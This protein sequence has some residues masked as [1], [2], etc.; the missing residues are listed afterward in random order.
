MMGGFLMR[1][2]IK[3]ILGMVSV[4]IMLGGMNNANFLVDNERDQSNWKA[5]E[6]F[7]PRGASEGMKFEW[8]QN[9]TVDAGLKVM[10][11]E[12]DERSDIVFITV[13]GSTEV[14]IG[15][16][17]ACMNRS[18]G[19]I[20]WEYYF[21][22]NGVFESIIA[23]LE[24]DAHGNLYAAGYIEINDEMYSLVKF[25]GDSG[26]ILWKKSAS[27]YN[28]YAVVSNDVGDVYL[29]GPTN[30]NAYAI[31]KFNG[32]NGNLL[33]TIPVANSELNI[34]KEHLALDSDQNLILACANELNDHSICKYDSATGAQLWNTTWVTSI[35]FWSDTFLAIDSQDNPF[36]GGTNTTGDNEAF[37]RKFDNENGNSL[38]NIT[39]GSSLLNIGV[40][41]FIID[42]FD[43]MYLTGVDSAPNSYLIKFN[44]TGEELWNRTLFPGIHSDDNLVVGCDSN[45]TLFLGRTDNANDI[46]YLECYLLC[47]MVPDPITTITSISDIGNVSLTWNIPNENGL[48]ITQYNI[49]RGSVSGG[50][51]ELIGTSGTNSFLD[52]NFEADENNIP[53][54][55]SITAIN[56]IGESDN[57]TDHHARAGPYVY[58]VTPVENESIVFGIG[59]AKL[60][61][62]YKLNNV[63]LV[64]LEIEGTYRLYD[65]TDTIGNVTIEL[66]YTVDI[67]GPVTA[68]L[69]GYQGNEEI[70]SEARNFTFGKITQDVLEVLESNTTIVGEVLYSIL[71]DPMG[72]NSY[73]SY[74]ESTT[75]EWGFSSSTQKDFGVSLEVGTFVSLSAGFV[76]FSEVG[77]SVTCAFT[78]SDKE[79]FDTIFTATKMSGMTSS[80]ET[81]D[82]DRIGP[83]RG[84]MYWGQG[85][86]MFYELSAN[87][88]LYFNGTTIYEDP[89]IKY[90]LNP[91]SDIFVDHA[92]APLSWK[93][94]NP[95]LYPEFNDVT[96]GRSLTSTGGTPFTYT[97]QTSTAEAEVYTTELYFGADAR[98]AVPALDAH[99]T[100]DVYKESIDFSTETDT[101]VMSYTIHDDDPE[102]ILAQQIGVD[103]KQGT[104]IF[105]SVEGMSLTSLPLEYDTVDYV[106]PII[107]IPKIEMDTSMDGV[108]PCIDDTPLVTVEL[109]EEGGFQPDSVLIMFS[110]NDGANWDSAILSETFEK[111]RIWQGNIPT[112]TSGT[113]VLWYIFAADVRGNLAERYDPHGNHYHYTV[114]NRAPIISLLTPIGGEEYNDT[115]T[116]EWMAEDLDQD[117]MT[118]SICYEREGIGWFFIATDV[119]G[120]SY[121]WNMTEF[122]IPHGTAFKIKVIANDGAGGLSEDESDFLFTAGMDMD[123]YLALLAEDPNQILGFPIEIT[124]ILIAG[125]VAWL[126]F[127]EKFR[128][129]KKS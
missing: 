14:P 128:K 64:L 113:T 36:L 35:D 112:T 105:R 124:S 125:G 85:I 3:T 66:D 99:V 119:T 57:S 48:E 95:T 43:Q 110:K 10:D 53:F 106:P 70:T 91:D 90:I 73:S 33:Q 117:N 104:F 74:E 21:D 6:T 59:T 26:L 61:I 107:G 62:C 39:W 18:N 80:Q 55:Y 58:W 78:Y 115:L 116:I 16:K 15:C 81:E 20:L 79:E 75:L 46:A 102:D 68:I 76:S 19:V 77:A 101:Q 40:D 127:R 71:H 108:F 69:H 82:P 97:E 17:L 87:R 32:Q 109:F 103:E 93:Y 11:I 65:V 89:S 63:D 30:E 56:E 45:E 37:I 29:S 84:D 121:F 122:A 60:D 47:D 25:H 52:T 2:K 34:W 5:K 1:K 114:I 83:G 8:S 27:T 51:K 54:Y 13:D 50:I 98:F 118:F 111:S 120:S 4:M 126:I 9:F 88:R 7:T 96:W 92:N 44:H 41:S 129:W 38:A 22:E 28:G 100:V 12:Y 42:N 86:V 23:D 49:Y 31:W 67:D 123:E 24:V 94:R 72:D